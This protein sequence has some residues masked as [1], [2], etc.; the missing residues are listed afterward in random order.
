MSHFPQPL[1]SLLKRLMNKVT[2]VIGMEFM[3]GLRNIKFHSSRTT[4]LHPLLSAQSVSSRNHC[5]VSDQTQFPGVIKPVIW[6]Q[7]A[8]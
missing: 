2:M 6:W 4:C 3:H 7:V 8:Y 1:L 5:F